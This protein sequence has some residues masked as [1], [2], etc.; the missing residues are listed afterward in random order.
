[1]MR[2]L[3]ATFS[4]SHHQEPACGRESKGYEPIF[5]IGMIRIKNSDIQRV[6]QDSTSF[7]KS[8][9]VLPQVHL[10]FGGIPFEL[11]HFLNLIS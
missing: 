10:R 11:Y 2:I 6:P 8:N 7:S 9:A 3:L 4:M 5:L 1:M